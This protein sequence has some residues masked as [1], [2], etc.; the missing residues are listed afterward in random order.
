MPCGT[1]LDLVNQYLMRQCGKSICHKYN[2]LKKR[3]SKIRFVSSFCAYFHKD[4]KNS[5]SHQ[6][7]RGTGQKEKNYIKVLQEEYNTIIR[8]NQSQLKKRQ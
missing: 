7:M 8:T 4:V 1:V 2:S 3:A 5:T 6:A